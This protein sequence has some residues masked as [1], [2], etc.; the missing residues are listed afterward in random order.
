VL[1]LRSVVGESPNSVIA[2]SELGLV[3]RVN[4]PINPACNVDDPLITVSNN[5]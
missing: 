1:R 3:G 2:D 4:L 5:L